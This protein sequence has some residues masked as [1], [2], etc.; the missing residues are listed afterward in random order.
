MYN[1]VIMQ[2]GHVFEWA[3]LFQAAH[4]TDNNDTS[5]G[6]CLYNNKGEQLTDAQL[7]SYRR[8]RRHLVDTGA[9]TREHAVKKHRELR[10]ASTE[11]PATPSNDAGASSSAPLDASLPPT[12]NDIVGRSLATMQSAVNLAIR[13]RTPRPLASEVAPI[14]WELAPQLQIRPEVAFAQAMIETADFTFP[15]CGTTVCADYCNPCGMRTKNLKAGQPETPN[16]HQRFPSWRVGVQ[17]HLDHLALYVGRPGY[18][19]PDNQTPDPRHFHNLFGKVTSLVNLGDWWVTGGASARPQYG[20]T[21]RQRITMMQEH[22]DAVPPNPPPPAS[23]RTTIVLHGEGW[24]AIAGRALDDETRWQEVRDL[25]GNRSLHPGEKVLLPCRPTGRRTAGPVATNDHC[26]AAKAGSPSLG[27]PSTTRHAGRRSATSTT[28][29]PSTR[30]AKGPAPSRLM[31]APPLGRAR[32]QRQS[33]HRAQISTRGARQC[34]FWRGELFVLACCS[35]P[36]FGAIFDRGS[37]TCVRP[38]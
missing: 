33:P 28:T 21:I 20:D 9:L 18:P 15:R 7:N 23:Q 11:C 32:D 22:S 29:G 10:S 19:K 13:Q 3:G 27:A 1:Y 8:L 34:L 24:I 37:G 12:A 5:I 6:V 38:L 25:N 14:Y 31:A 35:V 2:G 17:A 36:V 4:A 26:H 16:N 30:A